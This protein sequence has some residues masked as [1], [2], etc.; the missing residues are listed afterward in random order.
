MIVKLFHTLP[1]ENRTSSEVYAQQLSEA[2][3]RLNEPEFVITHMRASSQFRNALSGSTLGSRL[4]GWADRYVRY[5]ANC[6]GK[7]ADV[8]H[9]L[10][11]GYAHLAFSLGP[12][13]CVVS[14]HDAL[15]LKLHAGEIPG[16]TSR[17]ALTI[18]GHR[19]SLE[20]LKECGQI[21]VPSQQTRDDLVR[22][23]S[24]N[25]ERVNV[26]P[27][28]PAEQFRVSKPP[29]TRDAN[30]PV[31]ILSIG[32][33]GPSKNVETILKVVDLVKTELGA[34]VRLVRVGTPFTAAQRNL[35]N[36]LKIADSIEYRG[37][38]EFSELPA[39]YASCDLLL[40]PSHY[41]GF[42]LPVVEAMASGVPVVSSNAGSL[43]EVVGDAG[44]MA[45]PQDVSSFA[46]AI[47]RIITDPHHRNAQIEQGIA[48]VKKYSWEA[49]AQATLAVYRKLQD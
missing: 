30:D 34:N 26:V 35:A 28:A 6:L 38:P 36:Q 14:F 33:T 46:K 17:P 31:R 41:E 9:I 7:S 42:G 37:E 43:P 21:I 19:L 23:V 16:M 13:H 25:P 27:L 8:N 4:G 18:A 1:G 2:I 3:A 15:L 11:H 12:S 10:D 32:H 48:R 40:M 49:T 39:I 47:G 29:H 22:F 24:C 44:F 5:Q 20:A 45:D